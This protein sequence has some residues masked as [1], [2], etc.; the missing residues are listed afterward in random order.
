MAVAPPYVAVV[1][2]TWTGSKLW[3]A[4]CETRASILW[5]R[6]QAT[7]TVLPDIATHRLVTE[8][9]GPRPPPYGGGGGFGDSRRASPNRPP[10]AREATIATSGRRFG[11]GSADSTGPR[12]TASPRPLAPAGPRPHASVASDCTPC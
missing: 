11:A 2:T 1:P 6:C 5:T 3:P 9:S 12:P 10:L 8:R 7:T 4:S